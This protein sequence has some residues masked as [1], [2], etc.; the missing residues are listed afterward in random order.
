M[1]NKVFNDRVHLHLSEP[2]IEWNR[3]KMAEEQPI[4]LGRGISSLLELMLLDDS[5]LVAVKAIDFK[6][7]AARALKSFYA[8]L[9]V[10][11]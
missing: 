3:L 6:T 7:K 8:E 2:V 11:T 9:R 4:Y 10:F 5:Q 1:I